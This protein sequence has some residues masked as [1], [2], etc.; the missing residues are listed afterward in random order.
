MGKQC[1]YGTK[2]D[3]N[4]LLL[5]ALP[6]SGDVCLYSGNADKPSQPHLHCSSYY[7]LEAAVSISKD[8]SIDAPLL[9][10]SI[11][12]YKMFSFCVD[13][14]RIIRWQNHIT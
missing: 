13:I 3:I 14:R 11:G 4:T 1:R 10:T 2:D 7:L 8:N 5:P 6:S 9:P 12:R